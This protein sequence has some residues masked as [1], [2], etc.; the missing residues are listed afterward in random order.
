MAITRERLRA[1]VDTVPDD[2]L[3]DAATALHALADPILLAFLN[4]PDDDE[5]TTDEDLVA[6]AEG[7][8]AYERGEAVPL[9]T[10]MAELDGRP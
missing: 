4:A 1:L 10:V 9:A 3:D 8:A 2:R 5:P 6:I 7:N